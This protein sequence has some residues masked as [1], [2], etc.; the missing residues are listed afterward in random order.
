M[1]NRRNNPNWYTIARIIGDEIYD[2]F[3]R[4]GVFSLFLL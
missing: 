3:Y 1:C 2:W 4:R